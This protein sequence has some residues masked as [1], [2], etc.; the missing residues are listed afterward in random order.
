M[1]TGLVV[2]QESGFFFGRNMDIERSF[3]ERVVITPRRFPLTF[4]AEAPRHEGYATIGVG[5]VV[6]DYPLYAEA[7]NEKGLCAA[8]LNF[9]GYAHYA[10]GP[11]EG[12]C[13]VAAYELIS[14]ILSRYASVDE[15][16][17]D[18]QR[19]NILDMPF[20]AGLP[21]P[22]L[23]WLVA[24]RKRA[25]VIESTAEGLRVYDNPVGVLTNNPTFDWQLTNLRQ[26]MG[27]TPQQPA[28]TNW[29]DLSLTPLGQGQ[30]MFGMPG[31]FAP[32]SRFVKAAFLRNC[33]AYGDSEAETISQ[34]FHVLDAVAM[35]R[36]SVQLPNGDLD[37]T[38]YSSCIAVDRG[39]YF[40]KTAGNNQISAVD[41]H[42][43]PLDTDRLLVH[44][45]RREQSI[46]QH[47][48]VG[49][50]DAE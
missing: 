36:G 2:T 30:G 40:Y 22:P 25:V 9:P 13:N 24:D 41:L 4:K 38:T 15:A 42:A 28:D 48:P 26:F 14:W 10:N 1:C 7:A 46:Y 8:G 17:P 23:H 50:A 27:L 19:L 3:G 16:Y 6:D 5:S 37:L 34:F 18:L 29:G 12:A 45:L 21:V 35:V 49:S 39:V 44:E 47:P 11:R 32:P 20:K 33:A 31:D 43:E